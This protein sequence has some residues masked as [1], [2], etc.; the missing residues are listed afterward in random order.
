M[1]PITL[2]A[3]LLMQTPDAPRTHYVQADSGPRLA[4]VVAG[5]V[6][7][8]TVRVGVGLHAGPVAI[9]T[10]LALIGE[11]GAQV[12]GDGTGMVL[13][14]EAPDVVVSGLT[15]QGSGASLSEEDAG[16]MAVASPRLRVEDNRLE[17]VLFGIYLKESPHALVRGNRIVGKERDIAT[18][19][20]GIRFWYSP[21][22]LVEDN[23]LDRVRDLV[24]WFSDS[25]VVRE[26]QIVNSR[27]GL[28]YMYSD[29]TRF[30]GNRFAGNR[31]GAYL[32]YSKDIEFSGN[33]FARSAGPSGMG[34]GLKDTDDV[35]A[36]ANLLVAN[37]TGIY[38]DNS[39]TSA[40]ASNLFERNRMLGN[41]VG[42]RLLPAVRDNRFSRNEFVDNGRDA[43]VTGG[44]TARANDWA[45]NHW[46]SYA[47]FDR[48]RDGSGDTPYAVLKL[49][50]HI[51][52]AHPELAV[53]ALSP[54]TA[55]LDLV[56]Q[57]LPFLQPEPVLVDESPLLERSAVSEP[58]AVHAS[59]T[60]ALFGLLA[61]AALVALYRLLVATRRML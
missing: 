42:V 56:T 37:A 55:I 3:A 21:A 15:L 17:D 12:A 22:G 25:L 52:S 26:N 46:S 47:G 5:A 16:I 14:V 19:G 2:L 8:D 34:I 9:L 20:D 57:V 41:D 6:A 60:A 59:W 48:D 53:F 43:A 29:H 38:L 1:R 50:D 30:E 11:P 33:V 54:A 23:H 32:M 51:A 18:R 61:L 13:Y 44:G 58:T 36:H 45:A 40:G 39:P 27:Y 24:I 31:V 28:H 4:Q 35:R 10:S 49:S 7:G